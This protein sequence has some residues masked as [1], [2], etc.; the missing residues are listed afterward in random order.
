M[1]WSTGLLRRRFRRVDVRPGSD[2]EGAL[3]VHDAA[4]VSCARSSEDFATCMNSNNGRPAGQTN[5]HEPHS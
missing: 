5:V 2:A 1:G 4:Y 3:P